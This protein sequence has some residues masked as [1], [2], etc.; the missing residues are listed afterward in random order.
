MTSV[1]DSMNA[2]TSM[3][4]LDKPMCEPTT[5]EMK[6]IL[7]KLGLD[8]G[9]VVI[10][11]GVSE[12][13][14]KVSTAVLMLTK[15]SSGFPYTESQVQ[16]VELGF[17][18]KTPPVIEGGKCVKMGSL[19]Q[20]FMTLTW[21][22]CYMPAMVLDGTVYME[23]GKIVEHFSK[24]YPD[25]S[26]SDAERKEVT[27]W[28]DFNNEND[29]YLMDA[30][31]HWGWYGFKRAIGH[32]F[33]KVYGPG[34]RSDEWEMNTF[35]KVHD[36]LSQCEHHFQNKKK[37]GGLNGYYV[38]NKMTFADCIMI[39]WAQTFGDIT[40]MD[41]QKHYPVYYE[42]QQILIRLDPPGLKVHVEGFSF[43]GKVARTFCLPQNIQLRMAGTI[44]G[45]SKVH[46]IE[47]PHLA[48]YANTHL[49]QQ[50]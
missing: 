49:E 14:V 3:G 42:N 17:G 8:K 4:D 10:G 30:A 12:K 2:N 38:G 29:G 24:L 48:I 31:I 32:P 43:Y 5:P 27:K 21:N 36:F 26:L 39:N 23:A 28:V 11:A 9:C 22:R 35:L 45:A 44:C 41:V 19:C 34:T 25:K 46:H 40:G 47:S 16:L 1:Y 7:Q 13:T 18:E 6:A 33:G 15:Q 50:K 20:E 37:G